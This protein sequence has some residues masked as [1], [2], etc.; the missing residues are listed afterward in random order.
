MRWPPTSRTSRARACSARRCLLD[1]DLVDLV[2][3]GASGIAGAIAPRFLLPRAVSAAIAEVGA[4]EACLTLI[5]NPDADIAPFSLDRIVERFGHL[6][7]IRENLLARD[8]LP[9][10]TRQ[11]L[12]A[13]LS[14]TLAGF[15]A[16]RHWLPRITRNM[17]RAKPARRRRSR[18]PP[19]RAYDE[20]GR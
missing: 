17:P 19:R 15:V 1:A 4:G 8:D 2:A 12:V 13:K 9:A 6:A 20:I 11:A 7:A 10:A 5:E 16:A 14:Q 3:T 18:S